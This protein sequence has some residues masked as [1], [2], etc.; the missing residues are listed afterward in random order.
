[1]NILLENIP[2]EQ[3]GHW[4]LWQ[5]LYIPQ[6]TAEYNNASLH[7][8]Q[9]GVEI[10]WQDRQ[11][12]LLPWLFEFLKT[13]PNIWLVWGVFWGVLPL[14]VVQGVSYYQKS[15][16]Q[17]WTDLATS[18]FQRYGHNSSLFQTSLLSLCKQTQTNKGK[19]VKMCTCDLFTN[20]IK[21]KKLYYLVLTSNLQRLMI[22]ESSNKMGNHPLTHTLSPG[23]TFM[24][25]LVYS[26]NTLEIGR[27]KK[28]KKKTSEFFNSDRFRY[29]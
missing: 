19:D 26:L 14:F 18:A 27:E 5:V 4:I 24:S 20:W 15:E 16:T 11:Y 7:L 9:D 1:M 3:I 2:T 8:G 21:K 6:N 10:H 22:Q 28:M 17:F 13:N 29:Y 12:K 25:S 23:A